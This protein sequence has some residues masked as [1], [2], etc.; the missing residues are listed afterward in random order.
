MPQDSSGQA[1]Q[2]SLD[3][4]GRVIL[5]DADVI[6]LGNPKQFSDPYLVLRE[7]IFSIEVEFARSQAGAGMV[8]TTF[9]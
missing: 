7:M 3:F 4:I 1:R 5:D 9:T 6:S 8:T 2:T